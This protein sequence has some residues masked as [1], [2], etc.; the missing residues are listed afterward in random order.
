MIGLPGGTYRLG[1][2]KDQVILA[3]FCMDQ[4]K[5]TASEMAVCINSGRCQPLGR[6]WSGD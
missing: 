3:G 5:V 4:N 6:D 2:R 1:E